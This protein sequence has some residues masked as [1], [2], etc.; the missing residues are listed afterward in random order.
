M[1]TRLIGA[2]GSADDL[3]F[4]D[5][6]TIPRWAQSAVALAH[7]RNLVA[8]YEDDTFRPNEH[9]TREEA[10]ALLVRLFDSINGIPSGFATAAPYNDRLISSAWALEDVSTARDLGLLSGKPDNLFGPQDAI[11]RAETAA[12][13][14]NL[15]NLCTREKKEELV[16]LQ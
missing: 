14:N 7:S 9:I 15:L 16:N 12:A 3:P 6:E 13:L 4:K 5:A 2:G 10:A 1:I 8:G 11:T